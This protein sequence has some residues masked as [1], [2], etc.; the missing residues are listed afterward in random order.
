MVINYYLTEFVY[1]YR[2]N[3]LIINEVTRKD[4]IIQKRIEFDT[5]VWKN[6]LKHII[7]VGK[8]ALKWWLFIR[9]SVSLQHEI[10]LKH[11][12]KE[13]T[14]FS[15]PVE[16]LC[17]TQAFGASG[18]VTGTGEWH[19]MSEVWWLMYD[20]WCMMADVW[21]MRA[22]GRADGRDKTGYVQ[23]NKG[24]NDFFAN[25]SGLTIRLAHYFFVPLRSVYTAML[26][27]I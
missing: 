20:V 7:F 23:T 10:V 11:V 14:R 4:K 26:V 13:N 8:S 1:D 3:V 9:K 27:R 24:I 22:E 25:N 19:K 12:E 21:C 15:Y 6:A 17:W 16:R 2:N 18:D 5:F